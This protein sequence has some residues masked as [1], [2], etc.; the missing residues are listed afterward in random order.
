L[1][2]AKNKPREKEDVEKPGNPYEGFRAR[3]EGDLWWAMGQEK[4][5]YPIAT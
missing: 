2:I 5:C 1:H 3:I 4:T